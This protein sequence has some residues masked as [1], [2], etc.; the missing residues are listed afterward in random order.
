MQL[1][2]E[3][4]IKDVNQLSGDSNYELMANGFLLM[5]DRECKLCI[6]RGFYAGTNDLSLT[7]VYF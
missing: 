2:Y 3:T 5:I 6:R 4:L 7:R 1:F